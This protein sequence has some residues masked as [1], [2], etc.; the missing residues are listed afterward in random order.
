MPCNKSCNYFIYLFIFNNIPYHADFL[1]N[2]YINHIIKHIRHSVCAHLC[3][4]LNV[5]T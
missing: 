4:F 5:D 2:M 3:A 1:K